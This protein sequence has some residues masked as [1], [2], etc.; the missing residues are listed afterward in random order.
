MAAYLG[1]R[2]GLSVQD[3]D[4]FR[5]AVDE[6]CCLFLTPGPTDRTLSCEFAVSADAVAVT[7]AAPVQEDFAG[8]QVGTFGW[9]LLESLVDGLWWS[10]AR[11]GAEV[12]LLKRRPADDSLSFW[13]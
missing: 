13:V 1:A 11:R 2:L 6:A 3:V 10:T 4:D 8:R 5:L 7:L 12:R 9:S